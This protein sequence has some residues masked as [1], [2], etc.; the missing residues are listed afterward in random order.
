MANYTECLQWIDTLNKQEKIYAMDI[1]EHLA[2][3]GIKPRKNISNHP[4]YGYYFKGE[5][6]LL[7]RENS[8]RNTP[9][10]IA[11][12]YGLKGR[13]HDIDSFVSACFGEADEEELIKYIIN[14]VC[15]CDR[16]NGKCNFY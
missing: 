12:Y 8:W 1:H 9:L 15:C 10:Y 6:V 11:I 2:N 14:N 3:K 16:G 5:R 7:L 4:A 13:L